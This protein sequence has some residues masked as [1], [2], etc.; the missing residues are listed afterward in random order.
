M[1]FIR[2]TFVKAAPGVKTVLSGTVTSSTKEALSS[3]L[4]GVGVGD[5]AAAVGVLV[6]G[7]AVT[8]AAG[9]GVG[10]GGAFV[11]GALVTFVTSGGSVTGD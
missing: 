8:G 6:S 7:A 5:G 1:F 4:A 9:V 10:V 2:Q 11:L 3:Q